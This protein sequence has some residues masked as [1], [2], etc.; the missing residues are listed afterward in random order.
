MKMESQ[1]VIT[2]VPWTQSQQPFYYWLCRIPGIGSK[3]ALS[4]LAQAGSPKHIYES[5]EQEQKQWREQNLLSEK[6]LQSLC[7]SRRGRDLTKEYETLQKSGISMYP[8]FHPDYPASLRPV[9]DPPAVLFG[10]G[11]LPDQ[12]RPSVAI[13]GA[14][15]CS[16]YGRTMA[17][18]FA[19]ALAKEGVQ[20]I[21]GMARGIDGIGQKA[22]LQA[23]GYSCGV[24]G[25]G[26]DVCY[27][28]ENQE[29][30]DRLLKQ[31]GILSEYLPGTQPKPAFFPP[32][33]RII[34]GLADALLVVEARQKSG[35]LI[36]V[37]MALE[38]GREV[39]VLPGRVGDP[40]SQGC[41]QLIAQGA[42][43]AFS[44]RELLDNLY[45]GTKL[46]RE[47][48][49]RNPQ[50][51]PKPATHTDKPKACA[52]RESTHTDELKAFVYGGTARPDRTETLTE[53]EKALYEVLDLYPKGP[54]QLRRA[55]RDWCGQSLTPAQLM[56]L[57]VRLCMKGA[58]CRE[59]AGGFRKNT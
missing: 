37:D 56:D 17:Y 33:N 54:E 10:K 59:P 48:Q 13:I 23:G 39:Y 38:Q 6:Q 5:S 36:T 18:E 2:S 35:T 32:R 20:I 46:F 14:R 19:R 21:S 49:H 45:A 15:S 7:E 34:S 16:L 28:K 57:L 53:Q 47:E 29:L 26:V 55:Y 4:L 22:A 3:T 41:N 11:R 8:L 42:A 40:L 27:P 52:D 58:A 43:I 30:Y 31:G 1:N 24:L 9:P 25:C 44:P 50:K 51:S 12:N